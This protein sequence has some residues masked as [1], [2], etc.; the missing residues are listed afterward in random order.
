MKNISRPFAN[1]D[2][3]RIS[4]GGAS[5]ALFWKE[6]DAAYDAVECLREWLSGRDLPE[7]VITKILTVYPNIPSRIS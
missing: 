7:D 2:R 1:K 4:E 3:N 5:G 6:L